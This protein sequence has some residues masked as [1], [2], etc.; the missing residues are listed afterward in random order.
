MPPLASI[1]VLSWNGLQHLDTCLGSLCRQT[2]SDVEL[3]L[4]DNGS[5][6]GTAEYVREHFP[7]V[8]IERVENNLGVPGGMNHGIRAARGTFIGILNNDTEIDPGW[9]E[10]CVSALR[11]HPEAGA[12]ASRVRL[13]WRRTHLDTAGDVFFSAGMVGKRGWLEADGPPFDHPAWV[14]SACAGTAFYR[15]QALDAAGLFDEDFEA[16]IEDVDLSFRIQL[17]GWRCLYVPEAIVYHKLG[18]TVGQGLARPEHQLRM[19][20]NL[21]YMRI[22]DLPGSLWLRHLPEMLL[23]EALVLAA[24]LRSGRIGVALRARGQVLRALPALLRKRRMIQRRRR[25]APADIDAQIERGWI[26][27]RRAEKRREATVSPT[28]P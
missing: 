11:N 16:C 4:V 22:K 15:R 24:S 28:G 20:R 3:I 1:V 8:R 18:A 7:N 21:W 25:A 12:I 19:H 27:H 2:L 5:T 17:A 6:D 10:A 14:F 13:F 26:A 9:A 23:A